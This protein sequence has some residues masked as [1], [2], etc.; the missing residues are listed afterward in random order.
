MGGRLAADNEPMRR[1][2][3]PP[4]FT[5]IETKDARRL[6]GR[7]SSELQDLPQ[8]QLLTRVLANGKRVSAIRVPTELLA[9]S[10]P[11]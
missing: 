4:A 9:E 11:A 1:F 7:D 6:T 8:V 3:T 5:I 2:N 10:E